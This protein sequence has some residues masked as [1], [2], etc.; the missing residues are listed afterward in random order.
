MGL[1]R[2]LGIDPH[3][4]AERF[5][6]EHFAKGSDLMEIGENGRL[7]GQ[8]G[9]D[10]EA[11]L[12]I[13]HTDSERECLR[14][15]HEV[16]NRRMFGVMKDVYASNVQWHGPMARELYGVAAVLTQA[17]RLIAMIP[18]AV[19]IPQHI[20]SVQSVEGG[21]KIAMRLGARR[22]P[23]RPRHARRADGASA[24]RDGHVALPHR[25]RQDRG[26]L[27]HL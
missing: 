22:P 20:C 14:W 6:A 4:L 25:Q 7:L 26:R 3:R 21:E 24:L 11:D 23:S 16:Y 2:Q 9:P 1:V 27:V 13:A 17:M 12:S 18:D 5:A 19:F 15:L 8:Y 10:D